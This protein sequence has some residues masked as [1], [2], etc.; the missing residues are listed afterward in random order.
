[1]HGTLPV[2]ADTVTDFQQ[3]QQIAMPSIVD[4]FKTMAEEA[5]F[6]QERG[7]KYDE[8]LEHSHVYFYV[9]GETCLLWL[10]ANVLPAIFHL[11]IANS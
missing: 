9:E 6:S 10:L 8:R 2:S 4:D 11:H 1:M 5:R 3:F 7:T